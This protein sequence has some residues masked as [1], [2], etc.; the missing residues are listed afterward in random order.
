MLAR[1]ARAIAAYLRAGTAPPPPLTPADMAEGAFALS[2]D[3]GNDYRGETDP[4]TPTDPSRGFPGWHPTPRHS[5][6]DLPGPR[7]HPP[8]G[9]TR[10]EETLWWQRHG[11]YGG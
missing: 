9:L 2:L 10:D 7:T 8:A 6:W 4:E 3:P 1:I 11:V 5:P